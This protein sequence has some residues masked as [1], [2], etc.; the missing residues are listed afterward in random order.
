MTALWPLPSIQACQ[1]TSRIVKV[2]ASSLG[3][4]PGYQEGYV[5]V[6]HMPPLTG[7]YLVLATSLLESILNPKSQ[8]LIWKEWFSR[9]FSGFTSR[10]MR[11]CEQ[12]TA[13]LE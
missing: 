1:H 13:L 11:P 9:M 10:W 5:F 12:G 8:T 6:T 7:T 2:D 4:I 3:A